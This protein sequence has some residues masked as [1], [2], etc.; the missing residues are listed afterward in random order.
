MVNK[1]LSLQE[2]VESAL[3]AAAQQQPSVVTRGVHLS[4]S[5]TVTA[6]VGSPPQR[7]EEEE[8]EGELLVCLHRALLSL[9]VEADRKHLT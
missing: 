3:V 7:S 2:S 8:E 1:D 9:Q 6:V 5:L 4:Q